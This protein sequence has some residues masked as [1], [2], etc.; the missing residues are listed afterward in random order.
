L[1]SPTPGVTAG[2][3][4]QWGNRDNFTDGFTSDIRKIQFSF[5][6]AFSKTY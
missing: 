6:Y 4:F 3:E 5:K 1:Y 2:V